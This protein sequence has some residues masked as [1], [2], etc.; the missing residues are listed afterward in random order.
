VLPLTDKV[1]IVE[2]VMMSTVELLGTDQLHLVSEGLTR[3]Y[4]LEVLRL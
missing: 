1:F 2:R 4:A 3:M